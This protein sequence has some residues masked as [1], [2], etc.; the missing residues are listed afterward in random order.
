ML[1]TKFI[2]LGIIEKGRVLTSIGVILTFIE[3]E[4]ESLNE[5]RKKWYLANAALDAIG[6]CSFRRRV[7]VPEWMA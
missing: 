1:E 7:C 6:M 5:L 3:Y 2:K 4:D